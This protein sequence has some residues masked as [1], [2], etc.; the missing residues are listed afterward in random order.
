MSSRASA[1]RYS[2]ALFDIALKESDPRV[3]ERELTEFQA[4]LQGHDELKRTL[5]SPGVSPTIKRKLVDALVTRGHA[6]T[7]IAKLLLLL[8]ERDRLGLLPDITDLFRER[9][10]EH[11]KMVRADITTAA[12][13]QAG[14]TRQL[15]QRLS[16][17]TQRRVTV[18]AK[19]D[20]AII[21]G[22]VARIGSTV[23]DGSVA[24]QLA[25]LRDRLVEQR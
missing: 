24:T 23:F 21:G 16:D 22:V 11:E 3:A 5:G 9:L 17:L 20:P 6:S 14:Q 12:P 8:A 4:L 13:L 7:P 18:T 25:R 19:V 2:R 10:M 15:E 1:A